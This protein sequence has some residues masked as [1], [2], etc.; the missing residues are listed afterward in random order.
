[1]TPEP[2][3]IIGVL[4]LVIYV[5]IRDIIIPTWRKNRNKG[6]NPINLDR[7]YQEFQDFK[8]TQG[9]FNKRIEGD[10]GKLEDKIN[11]PRRR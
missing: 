6:G 5:L 2:I 3:S 9:L 7:F 11:R 1:M 10:I 4:S 8:K